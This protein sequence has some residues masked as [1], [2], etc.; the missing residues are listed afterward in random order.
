VD[1]QHATTT[2]QPLPNIAYTLGDVAYRHANNMCIV[3]YVDGHVAAVPQPTW[4]AMVSP[5]G[6]VHIFNGT[7]WYRSVVPDF[8]D[9]KWGGPSRTALSSET[10]NYQGRL[11]SANVSTDYI[12]TCDPIDGGFHIAYEFTINPAT[13]YDPKTSYIFNYLDATWFIPSSALVGGSFTINGGSSIDFPSTPLP[14]SGNMGGGG[15]VRQYVVTLPDQ[16]NQMTITFPY[17]ANSMVQDDRWWPAQQFEF[18]LDYKAGT[19]AANQT[20]KSEFTLKMKG[21]CAVGETPSIA[22]GAP[23]NYTDST[24]TS[25]SLSDC[26]FWSLGG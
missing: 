12:A 21:G 15:N 9:A 2:A 24:S 3:R 23:T 8:N 14:S 19:F 4:K 1:G 25:P 13:T 5:Q 18:R 26:S 16:Q 7:T 11:S 10:G 22:N 20:K 17:A 6:W